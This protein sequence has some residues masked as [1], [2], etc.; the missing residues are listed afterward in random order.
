[1]IRGPCSLTSSCA[2][3]KSSSASSLVKLS[4]FSSSVSSKDGSRSSSFGLPGVP[5]D[6]SST[7]RVARC[8]VFMTSR[9]AGS[10]SSRSGRGPIIGCASSVTPS[11]WKTASMNGATTASDVSI[12]CGPASGLA[13]VEPSR[14]FSRVSSRGLISRRPGEVPS[15]ASNASPSNMSKSSWL[16]SSAVSCRPFGLLSACAVV[17]AGSVPVLR[18]SGG[19]EGGRGGPSSVEAFFSVRRPAARRISSAL[20]GIFRGSGLPLTASL[21]DSS[22]FCSGLLG[23]GWTTLSLSALEPSGAES[24]LKMSINAGAIGVG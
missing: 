5:L 6:R 2:N 4:T 3:A 11:C 15:N 21:P 24:S 13:G 1:M 16:M 14:M 22:L 8:R 7:L 9:T 23:E 17:L 12:G 20:P 10:H 18:R 19:G